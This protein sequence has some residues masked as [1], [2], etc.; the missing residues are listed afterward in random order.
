MAARAASGALRR[1]TASGAAS[2]SSSVGGGSSAWGPWA[3]L[4]GYG[5]AGGAGV[6]GVGLGVALCSDDVLHPGQ[7][8]WPQ[9]GWLTAFDAASVRRGHQVYTQVCAS[10]HSLDRI[11]YRNLVGVCYTEDEAK[12][13][14]EEQ[15]VRDGPNGEGEY[16]MRPGKLADYFPAP[17]PNEEAAR[18]A[19][20]GAYPPDL[21]LIVKARHD[22]AN[23]IFSL[24]TGYRDPPA[25]ITV[26]EGLHYN[27]YF[28]GGAIA[29]PQ[30]LLE[31]AAEY[32]DEDVPATPAQMAKDVV[33]FLNWAAEPEHDERKLMG[34]KFLSILTVMLMI[35]G[36]Y[37]RFRWAP[38]KSRRMV[39]DVIN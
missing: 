34:L 30:L 11:A 32:E 16:F 37:K 27:P 6:S 39:Y 18:F 29:M 8:K 15:E 13:L 4:F 25:G 22:G 31:G 24:L 26:R 2:S 17:Y 5:V 21:S 3:R 1:V 7:Y 36:Y 23:Y 20:G 12:R 38:I 28:P 14:A 10:C 19:N 9:D 33:T 35:T